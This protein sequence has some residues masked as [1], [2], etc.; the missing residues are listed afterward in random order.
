MQAC[1]GL[2][3]YSSSDARLTLVAVVFVEVALEYDLT[4]MQGHIFHR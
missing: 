4:F 1:I 3:Q 2:M